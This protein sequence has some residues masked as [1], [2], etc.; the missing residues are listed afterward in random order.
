M[1]A[2]DSVKNEVL[3][4]ARTE[5]KARGGKIIGISPFVSNDFD[6]QITTPDLGELTIFANIMSWAASG[7]YLGI[8]RAPIRIN[9][10]IWPKV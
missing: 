8:G 4:G 10:E 2:N 3:S 9:L 7:Y 5:L 1:T 6:N